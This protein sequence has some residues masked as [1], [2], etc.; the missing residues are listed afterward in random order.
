MPDIVRSQRLGLHQGLQVAGGLIFD[1]PVRAGSLFL[2]VAMADFFWQRHVFKKDMM[3]S[4]YDVKQEF[5]QSEGD[6][7]QKAQR[8]ARGRD[9]FTRGTAN[10]KSRR[11][12]Y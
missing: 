9:D 4:K 6:P 7:E 8:K 3:M 1:I 11:G 10:G 12:H 5:K 2:V